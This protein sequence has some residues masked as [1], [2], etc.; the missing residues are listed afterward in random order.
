MH[1]RAPQESHSQNTGS[2][3]IPTSSRLANLFSSHIWHLLGHFL[4]VFLPTTPKVSNTL[5]GLDKD[6]IKSLYME[7][8]IRIRNLD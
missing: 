3:S 5:E 4:Y 7:M 2:V 6:K 8:C 1:N